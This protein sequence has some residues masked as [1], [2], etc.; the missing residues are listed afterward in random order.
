[1]ILIRLKDKISRWHWAIIGFH[2]IKSYLYFAAHYYRPM[3]GSTN[4]TLR[5]SFAH[6]DRTV[7]PIFMRFK[8]VK[9]KMYMWVDADKLEVSTLTTFQQSGENR[10]WCV[11]HHYTVLVGYLSYTCEALRK[12]A[13][14]SLQLITLKHRDNS[15]TPKAKCVIPILRMA[16]CNPDKEA[17]PTA[18]PHFRPCPTLTWHCWPN[19]GQHWELNRL[20]RFASSFSSRVISTS[21]YCKCIFVL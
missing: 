10:K 9:V 17:I 11:C 16:D 13:Q 18:I 15:S 8:E 21:G 1:M 3:C 7:Q 5:Q 4:V 19:I 14:F 2:I 12:A 6:V 20:N